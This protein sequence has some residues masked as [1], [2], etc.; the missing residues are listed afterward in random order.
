VR[1]SLG[2][3]GRLALAIVLTAVVPLVA[4]VLLARNMVR[5]TA[6]RFFVPEVRQNIERSLDLYGELAK[7]TKT[8]MRLQAAAF[9]ADSALRESVQR[10]NLEAA[11][12]R[13]RDLLEQHPDIVSF[14]VE[15]EDGVA[16]ARA[17]RGRPVDEREENQLTVVHSLGTTIGAPTQKA[18]A[19]ADAGAAPNTATDTASDGQ[20]LLTVFATDKA[21]FDEFGKMGEF[22]SAYSKL[23][24][25]RDADE[26]T[27]VLAFAALLGITII[28]ASGVGSRLAVGV[29]RRASELARA[30]RLVAQGDLSIRVHEDARDELGDLARAFNRML[31]EVE[32]SR[33]RIEYLSRLASWQEMARRLAHEIKNP[34]TPIQLAMQEVHQRLGN[35]SPEQKQ[36]L[37]ISLEI[38]ETEVQTL[39]RLVGEFSE[40]ARLPESHMEQADLVGFLRELEREQELT[41]GRPSDMTMGHDTPEARV[42]FDL[43]EGPAVAYLDRQMLRR[44]LVN[45]LSNATQAA[46]GVSDRVEVKITLRR[47]QDYYELLVDDDGPGVPQALR[48]SVFEPYV[49][50]KHDGTGLGLAIVKKIV[51]EHRG[52]IEMLESPKGGARVRILLPLAENG[53]TPVLRHTG[54]ES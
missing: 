44:A 24:A 30:T 3:R 32:N 23:E 38:V 49:T 43:L 53:S 5:Q 4:A 14:S 9:A 34:L 13:L 21:R 41:E 19:D 1:L 12:R 35:L 26:Q 31:R 2:I 27:Y 52:H 40:F 25:R 45:L 15:D 47:Q 48:S 6:E 50:T 54:H 16:L 10:K 8:N 51:I 39:R 42:A 7:A 36:F 28:L 37:D 22:I 18:T 20:R 29:T 11:R 17:D 33:E 46:R